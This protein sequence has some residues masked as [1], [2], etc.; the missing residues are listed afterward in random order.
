MALTD[1]QRADARFHGATRITPEKARTVAALHTLEAID[2]YGLSGPEAD[3]LE[4]TRVML[5]RRIADMER[6]IAEAK[7]LKIAWDRRFSDA[8]RAFKTLPSERVEDVVALYDLA[9]RFM[10]ATETRLLGQMAKWG[11]R[12]EL[13]EMRQEALSS[14]IHGATSASDDI[15]IT[16]ARLRDAM[17]AAT[18]RH[19]EMVAR[20]NAM[21]VEEQLREA[22]K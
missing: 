12:A 21:L 3:A 16:V 10:T 15:T 6:D 22:G 17:P 4:T 19:A 13:R 20:I 14:L 5:R 7:R 9:G 18:A 1:H 2:F 8:T 11:A